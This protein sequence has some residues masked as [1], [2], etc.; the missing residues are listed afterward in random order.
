MNFAHRLA[1]FL[2][3]T[4]DRP[5]YYGF[6]HTQI[7][8]DPFT[9]GS[10]DAAITASKT[11]DPGLKIVLAFTPKENNTWF[12]T[13]PDAAWWQ[14]FTGGLQTLYGSIP[15]VEVVRWNHEYR[16]SL[17]APTKA[18]EDWLAA[19]NYAMWQYIIVPPAQKAKWTQ[20][21]LDTKE[22]INPVQFLEQTTGTPYDSMVWTDFRTCYK[23][24][25]RYRCQT[26]A[27]RLT[28][29]TNI[30]WA[31]GLQT[32]LYPGGYNAM[33]SPR[34]MPKT[35]YTF[36]Q[37]KVD[38]YKV[39]LEVASWSSFS[40]DW[41]TTTAA[42]VPGPFLYTC[43][44]NFGVA[45]DNPQGD[46]QMRMGTKNALGDHPW[47]YGWWTDWTKETRPELQGRVQ[48]YLNGLREVLLPG[49]P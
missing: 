11:I 13:G 44:M 15:N 14:I 6:T 5:S 19:N 12:T 26:E 7:A 9:L 34:L 46:Y 43:Q 36:D 48:K 22:K 29:L 2:A 18:W 17:Y 28:Q 24:W 41:L 8:F 42:S 23:E 25:I 27:T 20:L 21:L 47:G 32:M 45:E 33:I 31:F 40:A 39:L 37:L 49:Q 16:P 38:P 30:C 1:P 3:M 10:L 4:P 35:E